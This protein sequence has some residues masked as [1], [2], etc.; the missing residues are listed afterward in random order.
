MTFVTHSYRL[1]TYHLLPP[2]THYRS[3]PANVASLN[4]N[5]CSRVSL[6]FQ[7][8]YAVPKSQQSP[9]GIVAYLI[10]ALLFSPVG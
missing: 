5:Q 7:L 8:T 3:D 6:K 4:P 1:S 10:P 2:A 9:Q